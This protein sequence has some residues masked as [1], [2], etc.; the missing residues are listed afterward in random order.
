MPRYSQRGFTLLEL[1]VVI[2]IIGLLAG[3]VAPKYFGQVGKSKTKVAA[4]QIHLFGEAL[5]HYRLDTGHYP[6]TEQGLSVLVTR[7]ENEPRWNGPYLPKAIPN[8]PWDRPYLY[9][10]PGE[11]SEMDIVS[12]GRDGQPGGTG[13]DADVTNY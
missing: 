11:H 7:P 5:D 8:D 4:A 9:K 10:Q 2:V 3:F 13:E 1:L 6:T 12:L